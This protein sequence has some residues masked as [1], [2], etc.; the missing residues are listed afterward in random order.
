MVGIASYGAYIPRM[1]LQRTAIFESNRWFAP[2]LK[3]LAAGE[4]AIANWDE[5]T[6]TMAVEAARDCLGDRNRAEVKSVFLASTSFPFADRQNACIV[7]EALNLPDITGTLDIGASQKAGTGALIQACHAATAGG[8]PVLV[9][10]SENRRALPASENEMLNGDAA[11][12][13]LVSDDEGVA[14][15]IGSHSISS[16]FVSHF[17]A[18][19]NEFDYGWEARWVREEGYGRLVT[20]AVTQ[21]LAKFGLKGSDIDRFVVGLPAKG[22]ASATAKVTG[23]RPQAVCDDLASVL[24]SAGCAHPIIMFA[25]ALEQAKPRDKL[26][27]LGF[28]QGVDVLLFEATP[29]IV[30]DTKPTHVGVKGSLARSVKVDNYLKYLAFAG[31]L[32]LELGKRAEFDQKPVLTALYR[33][34][35][36]VLGLVGGRCTKSGTVQFPRTD[37]SVDPNEATIDTQED[38]PLAD[39]SATILTYTADHLTFTPDPPGYY[40]MIEFDGGGRMSTEFTDVNSEDI[41][42]GAPMRMMFRIKAADDNS[43]FIKYFW[44]AVPAPRSDHH[45]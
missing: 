24:G 1:R 16:D 44:K 33:N 43:G 37:I 2:G 31:H 35:K 38:Y 18:N 5:D 21:A 19:S 3:A 32:E 17:R 26:L 11:S 7:K 20:K 42:V 6:I 13:L 29:A 39:R 27:L 28:G 8:G 14:R 15:L 40:G 25:N 30:K 23:I 9:I 41:F 10:A 4:R 36:T 22:V 12:A 45:G 34:R